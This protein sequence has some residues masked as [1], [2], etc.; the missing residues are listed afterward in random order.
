MTAIPDDFDSELF[1]QLN[2]NH[3]EVDDMGANTTGIWFASVITAFGTSSQTILW[4]YKIPSEI[5]AFAKKDSI[6]CGILVL[7]GVVEESAT[8]EWA[9]QYNDDE[10]RREAQM[11]K[12]KEQSRAMMKENQLPPD[13]KAAAIR[14]RQL[15]SHDDWVESLNATRKRDVQRAETRMV[16][17]L[18]SPKWDNKLVAEHNL[19]WLKKEGHVEEGHDLKRAV[20]VLLWRM[21]NQIKIAED[22]AQML[23]AWKAFVDN[24]GIRRVDYQALKNSQVNFAYASLMIAIIEDSATAAHGSLAM[25][26]QECVRIVSCFGN[27]AFLFRHVSGEFFVPGKQYLISLEIFLIGQ[28]LTPPIPSGKKLGLAETIPGV[29]LIG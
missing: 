26:L 22:L 25:D 13:Q 19:S 12:M 21:V 27:N 1:D 29:S 6:P 10:E 4:N 18:Q 15:K 16:E 20:E 11:K 24:G 7:L 8:P 9:T 3:L 2:I 23:D 17:A 28:L 5:L 14:E